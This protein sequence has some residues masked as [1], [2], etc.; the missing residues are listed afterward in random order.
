MFFQH[1]LYDSSFLNIYLRNAPPNPTTLLATKSIPNPKYRA[2]P[3]FGEL[4]P[5]RFQNVNNG[6]PTFL[7]TSITDSE[8]G[9]PSWNHSCEGLGFQ[10]RWQSGGPSVLSSS[11]W[12]GNAVV[13]RPSQVI[14]RTL[15]CTYNKERVWFEYPIWMHADLRPV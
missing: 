9:G 8:N 10:L 2:S 12:R 15:I 4:K 14:V 3:A 13:I 11:H 6:P 5:D 7:Y 1:P